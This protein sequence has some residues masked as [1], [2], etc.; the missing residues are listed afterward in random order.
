MDKDELVDH[1]FNCLRNERS[2]EYIEYNPDCITE[3]LKFILYRESILA[4]GEE[5]ASEIAEEIVMSNR[6]KEEFIDYLVEVKAVLEDDIDVQKDFLRD[7]RRKAL[8]VG[9]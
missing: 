2:K 7:I 5:N 3:F 8:K 1:I 9:I 6:F 4:V